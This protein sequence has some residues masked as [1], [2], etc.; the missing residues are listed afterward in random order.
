MTI[1]GKTN[2]TTKD[3]FL[4]LH[5]QSFFLDSEEVNELSAYLR[6]QDWIA[7]GEA[8]FGARKAGEGN[9][10]YTLRVTTSRRTL[11]VKQARPWVEKYPQIAAPRERAVVEGNFY[12]LIAE[13]AEVA[14]MMPR[15]IGF[16]AV[17]CAIALEDLG[18]AS[19]FTAL[20]RGATLQ[21]SALDQLADYLTNLHAAFAGKTFDE[22]FANRAMR[23]L[24][25]QHIFD[26]PLRQE[27]LLDLDAITPGLRQAA[28]QL[29]NDSRYVETVTKLGELYLSGGDSR[30]L[31]H[32]DFFPGS[33]LNTATGTRV[34][35]PEFCFAG[36]A[37]F[38]LGVMLAHL[39]LANQ[40]A[41]LCER[42]LARYSAPVGFD[43]NL[44]NQFAG[45]EIMRRLIGV[46][47]LPIEYG[48]ERKAELLALSGKLVLS[49]SRKL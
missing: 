44:M 38:D 34:I 49:Q 18:E 16:D 35:D 13:R 4:K 21:E 5:P 10:N 41:L 40:N 30:V 26:L 3:Q 25:H 15:L 14:A 17:S 11:I 33:W 22:V 29:K 47:Q 7:A 31:L 6:Q 19:D 45:I 39:H 36:P 28:Q 32:G 20:Y 2:G 43:R 12:R 8:V 48:L 37:E 42:L 27:D 9:M 24:N 1:N 23:E 46:A